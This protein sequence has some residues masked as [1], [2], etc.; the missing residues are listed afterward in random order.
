M[1]KSFVEISKLSWS[2][3]DDSDSNVSNEVI[4]TGCLQRIASAT[5]LMASNYVRLQTDLDAYQRSHKER[6]DKIT[7]LYKTI[8]NLKGQIT[9][10]KKKS[11]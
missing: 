8:S 7:K 2:N 10:L 4:Q 5:E 1:A 9:K 3:L 11:A 6:G